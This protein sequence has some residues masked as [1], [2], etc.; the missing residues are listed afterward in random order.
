MGSIQKA[1]RPHR[2]PLPLSTCSQ[3]RRKLHSAH[4]RTLARLLMA[5]RGLRDSQN[6]FEHAAH[7]ED[8]HG[9]KSNSLPQFD[10]ERAGA[11]LRVA[12]LPSKCLPPHSIPEPL[13]AGT[14]LAPDDQ[15]SMRKWRRLCELGSVDSGPAGQYTYSDQ[16]LICS[17]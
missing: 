2:A 3:S 6:S 4:R 1:P 17:I 7:L 15:E 10:R 16:P 9:V 12:R 5:C 8:F 14:T 11:H 13:S